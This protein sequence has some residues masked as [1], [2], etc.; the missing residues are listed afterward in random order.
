MHPA[1]LTCIEFHD[2][3]SFPQLECNSATGLAAVSV[4]NI[5]CGFVDARLIAR[6]NADLHTP[7]HAQ[8]NI[9]LSR[10]FGLLK[11]RFITFASSWTDRHWVPLLFFISTAWLQPCHWSNRCLCRQHLMRNCGCKA[12]CS[13][14]CR[15]AH[16]LP[17]PVQYFT[18]TTFWL[19][20]KTV[21]YMSKHSCKCLH[22]PIRFVI[23]I[24]GCKSAR[25]LYQRHLV[26]ICGCK[27]RRLLQR[28]PVYTLACPMQHGTVTKYLC[29]QDS[30]HLQVGRGQS[31]S[32]APVVLS[33]FLLEERGCPYCPVW[34]GRSQDDQTPADGI[35][36]SSSFGTAESRLPVCRPASSLALAP[37]H[38]H[39]R[40]IPDWRVE[41]RCVHFFLAH[42]VIIRPHRSDTWIDTSRPIDKMLAPW[43]KL[44]RAVEDLSRSVA[45]AWGS[46]RQI[47]VAWK[48]TNSSPLNTMAL[49]MGL[50]RWA[51]RSCGASAATCWYNM[52]LLNQIWRG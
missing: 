8:C 49:K 50:T 51:C 18:V 28:R 38:W 42:S 44:A 9:S 12:H 48:L 41:P 33:K 40:H 15:P 31:P 34:C 26:R 14:Q 5:W 20:Q 24:I 36:H 2:R 10:Y 45:Q 27:A 22:E 21:H 39:Y 11:N 19:D 35:R 30:S 52:G 16:T 17:C 23:T 43:L 47:T 4:S 32:W 6:S 13:R 37:W 25:C 46:T 29:F 1:G 3:L 7:C